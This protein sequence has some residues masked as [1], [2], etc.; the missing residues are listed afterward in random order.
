MRLFAALKIPNDLGQ[1]LKRRQQ[2]LPGAK[3]RSLD[4]L[5]ITLRFFGE[6]TA[7]QAE[8]IDYQLQHLKGEPLTLH[9]E[10]VGVFHGQ[11]GPES[12]HALVAKTPA[13]E[14]L[15]QRCE[16]AARKAG[17]APEPRN[18]KPHVTLAYLRHAR[19]D[20]VAAW[21]SGHNLLR[22]PEFQVTWFGLYSSW[23]GASQSVYQLEREYPLQ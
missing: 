18:F 12:I 10:G 14:L 1:D 23:L 5:H 13:L 16:G 17:L 19:D 11:G 7:D 2:G 9:L 15:A 22:S 20:R 4:H 3:W 8:E 21:L 6:V